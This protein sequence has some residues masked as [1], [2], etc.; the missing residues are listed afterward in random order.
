MRDVIDDQERFNGMHVGVA[1]AIILGFAKGLVPG[2]EAHLFFLAPEIA[3]DH[4]NRIVQQSARLRMAGGHGARRAQ[5][6]EEMLIALLGGVDH[7]FIVHTGVPAAVLFVA[8]RAV[9]GINAVLNQGIRPGTPHI[10]GHRIHVQHAGGDP[11]MRAHIAT[12]LAVIAQ[13]AKAGRHGGVFTEIENTVGLLF[14]PAVMA[15]GV[16]PFH[17]R[18]LS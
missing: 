18:V 2:F 16:K 14:E 12:H 3:L 17:V 1:A 9:E 10:G 13:P 15:Q 6:H 11:Q 5:Q 4:L 8:Q 7:A